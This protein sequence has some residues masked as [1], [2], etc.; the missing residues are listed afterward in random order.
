M[1]SK[2][3]SKKKSK[4]KNKVQAKTDYRYS[5]ETNPMPLQNRVLVG[6]PMTGMVRA[7]WMLARYGQIIPTNWSQVDMIQW[8]NQ[9]SPIG[10][11][12]AD[13]RNKCVQ[14]AVQEDFEWLFFIDHDVLLPPDTFIRINDYMREDKYPVV[15]GLYFTKSNPPE[16]LMYRGRGT[17]FYKDW[18]FG[19][20]V[21]VDGIPMG[22]TLI[23]VKVLKE[24]YKVSEQYR[25]TDGEV[26]RRVFD[27]PRK[28]QKDENG[29]L[30]AQHG[31]EDLLWCTRAMEE[32]FLEKA[33][34]P[35]IQKKQYPFLLDTGIFCRHITN[36]GHRY[37]DH[38]TGT[39]YPPMGV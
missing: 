17:S 15:S 23:N 39:N 3:T 12:V 27:T 20:K 33:G 18:E 35:N 26:V 22:C 37:P 30:N 34:Y 21:W 13:A 10:Y 38:V 28:L 9:M 7:E 6:V 19:D 14:K 29:N 24:M 8:I 11:D 4:S 2:S 16:P 5:W 36:E 32:K 1:T 25:A 31:T